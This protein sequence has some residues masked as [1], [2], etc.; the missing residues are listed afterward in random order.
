MLYANQP[1]IPFLATSGK[2]GDF[3]I[4]T[5]LKN[6]IQIELGQ[7]NKIEISP[8]ENHAKIGGGAKTRHTIRTLAASG[9]RTGILPFV[10]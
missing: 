3:S 8:E 2:H 5:T 7:L 6:G 1:N 10:E 9:K 4:L